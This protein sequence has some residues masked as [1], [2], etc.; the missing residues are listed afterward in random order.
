MILENKRSILQKYSG[1]QKLSQIGKTRLFKRIF[2]Y[3]NFRNKFVMVFYSC[4]R[5]ITESAN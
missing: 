3:S 5:V 4:V 1:S 2:K